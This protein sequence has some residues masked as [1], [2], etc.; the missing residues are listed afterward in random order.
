MEE[1]NGDGDHYLRNSGSFV[2]QFEEVTW[3]IGVEEHS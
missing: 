3:V 2:S 1:A